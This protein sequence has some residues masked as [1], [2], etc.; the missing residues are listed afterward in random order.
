MTGELKDQESMSELWASYS[1]CIKC[2]HL[3]QQKANLVGSYFKQK[4]ISSRKYKTNDRAFLITFSYIKQ[5]A[6]LNLSSHM[7]QR[8][9]RRDRPDFVINSGI[10]TDQQIGNHLIPYASLFLQVLS[11][12]SIDSTQ[13][14]NSLCW[15]FPPNLYFQKQVGRVDI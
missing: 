12:N 10:A 2:R 1:E 9:T 5:I 6:N 8:C 7:L 14:F 4:C 3:I 11:A 15:H 13:N